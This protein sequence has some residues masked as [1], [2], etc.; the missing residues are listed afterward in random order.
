M[1][2][3]SKVRRR[4]QSQ[5][6]DVA[7]LL[8]RLASDCKDPARFVELFYWSREPELMA[9]VRQIVALPDEAKRPLHAFLRLAESDLRSVAVTVSANGDL[10]LSSPAVTS[11]LDVVDGSAQDRS[12]QPLH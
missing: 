3:P 11:L 1:R 10:T 7:Q 4:Y 2:A 8:R 5:E 6:S 9:I 12:T